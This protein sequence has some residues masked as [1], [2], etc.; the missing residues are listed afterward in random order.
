MT[1]VTTS[2]VVLDDRG[3]AYVEGTRTRVTMIVMDQMNGLTPEQ[4]HVEYPYLSLS[5]IHSALAYYY[6]HKQQLDT[7][8]EQEVREVEELRAH[9][10]A[11]GTQPSLA[12][13]ERRFKLRQA[14][15]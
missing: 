5:K 10:I 2:H 8:I 14:R 15:P 9:A 11:S 7:E 4:I 12:E 3:R 6:D 13:L 1:A